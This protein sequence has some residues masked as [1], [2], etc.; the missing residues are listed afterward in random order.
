MTNQTI[1][2][3]K[4]TS[5]AISIFSNLILIIIK[6]AAGI[7][8]GSISVLSEALHSFADLSASCLAYFSVSKSSKPA[9]D[10]HPFGHGKYEDLAGFIEAI[11]II[12]TALYI[13]FVAC[14]KI[15]VKG[16]EYEIQTTIGISI[17]L[18]SVIVNWAVSTYLHKV[19]IKTDS[20]ALKTD[21]EHLRA[22]IYSSLGIIAGLFAV[23]ITGLSIL[24]PI[25]AIFVATIIFRT[26]IKLTKQSSNNLLDG[27]LPN[28]DKNTIDE[29]I[30]EFEAHGVVGTKQIRTSKSGSKRLIQMTILLPSGMTLIEAHNICDKIETKIKEK[31]KNC[32]IMIHAEPFCICSK[33]NK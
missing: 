28:E 31:L 1:V 25:I 20:I 22:D 26:G 11:L 7:L 19:A 18:L 32:D 3:E 16:G 27:S 12:L 2:K 24:D 5:A 8:S 17:M 29:V 9:D 10:N 33:C 30:R 21:A 6:V 4:K 14:E 23:K 13:L 15:I